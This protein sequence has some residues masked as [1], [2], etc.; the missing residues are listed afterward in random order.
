MRCLSILAMLSLIRGVGAQP[1]VLRGTVLDD[2]TN[3][4]VRGAEALINGG[5]ARAFTDARGRFAFGGVPIGTHV[6]TIRRLGFAPLTTEVRVDSSGADI[7]FVLLRPIQTLSEVVV[8]DSAT[9]LERGKLS[10][11]YHRKRFGIGHFLER[12]VFEDAGAR[13]T[14]DVIQARIPGARLVHSPC[15]T[16]AYVASTRHGGFLASRG[17]VQICGR[18]LASAICLAA[19]LVDGV[20][21]YRG[22]GDPPFDVNS[23]YFRR[24]VFRRSVGDPRR[25]ES[26][27]RGLFST[28]HLD[29]LNGCPS[30]SIA[31]RQVSP[32]TPDG[33][34]QP[35]CDDVPNAD[36]SG[37]A[38]SPPRRHRHARPQ[39]RSPRRLP[40]SETARQRQTG[41]Q[42]PSPAST[43]HLTERSGVCRPARPSGTSSRTTNSHNQTPPPG[44]TSSRPNQ[45]RSSAH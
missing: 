2:F 36:C 7:D 23:E 13:R 19:V 41:N 21:V 1:G 35:S 11:F 38:Q 9:P 16:A 27:G 18:T 37:R 24:G 8:R 5:A 10:A 43:L 20:Y 42:R 39:G 30:K 15:G 17:G 29:A 33:Q 14:A 34:D 6:V 28:G 12:G 31:V 45:A 26:Y 25:N 4:A 44:A 40:A 22:T 32:R 3:A